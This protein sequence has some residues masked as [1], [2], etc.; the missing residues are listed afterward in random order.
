MKIKCSKY[1]YCCSVHVSVHTDPGL[2][3]RGLII[4]I[5]YNPGLANHWSF[6]TPLAAFEPT[7]NFVAR[8]M[9]TPELKATVQERMTLLKVVVASD[10]FTSSTNQSVNSK[11]NR[12]LSDQFV[13]M[14]TGLRNCLEQLILQQSLKL[15]TI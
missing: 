1:Q 10:V 9:R 15:A 7:L 12:K 5:Q 6:S 3:L 8:T 14:A 2:F 11:N 4:E 13:A